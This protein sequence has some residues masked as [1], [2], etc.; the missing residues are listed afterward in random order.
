MNKKKFDSL[1]KF[2]HFGGKLGPGNNNAVEYLDSLKNGEHVYMEDSTKRDIKFHR[3]YMGMMDYIH[4]WIKD[5]VKCPKGKF[6]IF[7][8][9]LRGLFD[10]FGTE[11]TEIIIYHSI[12]FGNM[13]QKRFE[14]YVKDELAFIYSD[15][16]RPIF[17]EDEQFES[18]VANIEHEFERFLS[19]L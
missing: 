7:V 6:Y 13:S 5:K 3:C 12:S 16:L 15:I 10:T 19:K 18:V 4:E 11:K 8:K 1:L 2:E 17:K 14:A 9:H